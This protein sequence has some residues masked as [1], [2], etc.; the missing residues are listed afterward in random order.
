[1]KKKFLL[2]PIIGSFLL[3]G[4]KINLFGKTIYLFEKPKES[5]P[6]EVNI[7][8][9]TP[10]DQKQH[11]NK[12]NIKPST[13][14]ILK[15]G[16]VQNLTVEYSP[17]PTDVSEIDTEFTLNGDCIEYSVTSTTASKINLSVKGK[18]AGY[19]EL[20]AQCKYNP[21]LKNT[22]KIDV[23]D[24]NEDTSYLWRF[25]KDIDVAP[26]TDRE[27]GV[28]QLGGLEWEF[29]RSNLVK[30]SAD[31][32]A[33]KFGLSK[34]PETEIRLTAHNTRKISHITIETASAN[35][36][37]VMNVSVGETKYI[38][39]AVCSKLGSDNSFDLLTSS[40][41]VEKTAGDIVIDVKTP[42]Y[43]QS[44]DT[45]DSGY[46]APGAFY[47]KSITIL[48]E[49]EPTFANSKK[50]DF[51][52]M[53]ADEEDTVLHT[54]PATAKAVSIV[55]DDYEI[56]FANAKKE[57][58]DIP[59]YALSNGNIDIKLKRPDEVISKIEFK[60]V[61]GGKGGVYSLS[62]TRVGGEPF[63]NTNT[64]GD[65]DGLIKTYILE[66][67]VNFVR[68]T[69]GDKFVGLEYLEIK[70]RTGVVGTIKELAKPEK[71]EPA[72]K[73]YGKND[74]FVP[75]GMNDALIKFN[76][77]GVRDVH[78]PVSL[79]EWYDGVSYETN[80]ATATKKLAVGTT[81]VVGVYRGTYTIEYQGIEVK[82]EAINVEKVTSVSEITSDGKYYL[83]CP[84]SH[85]ILK[86]S[87]ANDVIFTGNGCFKDEELVFSDSMEFNK[88]LEEDY[89][90][91]TA[92][93]NGHFTIKTPKGYFSITGS[94]NATC[95]STATN[96]REF[97]ITEEEGG[98]QFMIFRND[99][100]V[101]EPSGPKFYIASSGSI[102]KLYDSL[103]KKNSV[104]LYK[105]VA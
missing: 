48:F 84:T 74:E 75:D 82:D 79:L 54:L 43:E 24:Y 50:Y 76:E 65:G 100:T 9:V 64:K 58:E 41:S 33:L 12:M 94:G 20:T 66:D 57:T 31:T 18:A 35:S 93:S 16:E 11:S 17:T 77:I 105:V 83:A 2:L 68:L 90:T 56:N 86:G 63:A 104:V 10:D 72:K 32:G 36:Q 7:D 34:Q 85:L 27:S 91:F 39:D 52:A 42:K 62:T 61:D 78:L 59:E 28:A 88:A 29:S 8:D 15:V 4:C 80:P 87:S 47:I 45:P 1:M 3:T 67:N 102:I 53:Y 73:V 5:E 69:N 38:E 46:K 60:Y 51:K 26:F 89:L 70:T 13:R 19:C 6:T 101:E 81:K 30:V 49:D 37:S 98:L 97:E 44:Q 92:L 14:F 21:T 40:A 103:D 71:F 55:D 25:D 22:F 23:V 99:G 95:S 96:Y